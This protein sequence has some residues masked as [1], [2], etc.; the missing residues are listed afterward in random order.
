MNDPIFRDEDKARAH[1]E[2]SRWGDEP[3]CPHCGSLRVRKMGGR[4]QAGM[5]LCNDCRDKFTCRTGSVMERSH[6]PLHKWLLAIH[7]MCASKKGMSAKQMERM[8]GVTYKSAWFL[9]HR[10]RL[11]ME[12]GDLSRFGEGGGIVEADE[13]FIGWEPG[14]TG[15]NWP[16]KMK[17][18]ALVDRRTGKAR[19]MVMDK[20][21]VASVTPI[22]LENIAAEAHLMTDDAG[23]YRPMHRHFASHRTTAHTRKQY[24]DLA[25]RS[26]HS[27]TVEGYFSIFK[28]GMKGIYQHCSKRHLH[29]YA[30][31]FEF[32]YNYRIKNGFDDRARAVEGLKGIVGKRLTYRETVA[33]A[34]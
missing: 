5:F 27:N 14:S 17:V 6:I 25:D 10:I 20:I 31:E 3:S 7:L 18:L 9:C 12:S 34:S 16:D 28:R 26:V 1:I 2:R 24:V 33:R 30:A 32:R 13:T 23:Q 11:A 22:L 21:T 4:T 29:R 19:T 8:L 15:K